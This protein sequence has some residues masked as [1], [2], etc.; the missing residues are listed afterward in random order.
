MNYDLHT[1]TT[2]SDGA[3]T[4]DINVKFAEAV[5]LEA[6][7]ITDHFTPGMRLWEEEGLFEVYLGE[8]SRASEWAEVLVLKGV[9]ATLLGI[10]GEVSID[11]EVF[12]R[13]DVVLA[14]LGGHTEGV[15]KDPPKS[16]GKL[17][18]NLTRC[19]VNAASNPLFHILAHPFNL[20][21]IPE[22]IEPAQIPRNDLR[23][24]AAAMRENGK[25]FEVMNC[26]FW[27]FPQMPVRRFTKQ[28]IEIVRIFA[29]EGVSFSVGS[30][31]HRTGVGNLGWS[32]FVL[33]KA[34]VPPEQIV[35][36]RVFLGLITSKVASS[37]RKVSCEKRR[38][39]S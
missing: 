18:A 9:E 30:D 33:G 6:V 15:T 12:C 22:P 11:E 36:P 4:V 10:K 31:D 38:K 8:V 39:A 24:I 35:D 32:R 13:L 7:A 14:D 34:E 25:I 1:H 17:F 28:Y 3:H 29:E 20:G 19:L 27:W 2:F 26:T 37:Q 16:R 23:E 5:G 21:R